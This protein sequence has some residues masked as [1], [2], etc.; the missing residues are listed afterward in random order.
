MIK[1]TLASPNVPR[2]WRSS[3]ASFRM[4]DD[5][6]A[7]LDFLAAKD[8]R[9]VS[10]YLEIAVIDIVRAKL[11]NEFDDTG[12]LIGSRELRLREK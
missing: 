7:A 9:T 3:R 5:L 12:T 11:T 10:Q 2:I 6:R 8:R 1:K 4:S